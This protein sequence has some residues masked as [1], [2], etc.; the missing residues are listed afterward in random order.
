[1]VVKIAKKSGEEINMYH[2]VGWGGQ[3]IIILSELNTVVV[4]TGGNYIPNV[5][6]IEILEEYILPAIN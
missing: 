5:K 4:F 6:A 1:M 3:E 2:A